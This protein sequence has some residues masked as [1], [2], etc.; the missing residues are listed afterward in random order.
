MFGALLG[1][2]QRFRRDEVKQ[3]EKVWRFAVLA[4]WYFS[5]PG[6]RPRYIVTD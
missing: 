3:K 2:L 4:P 5:T 6:F 1:T